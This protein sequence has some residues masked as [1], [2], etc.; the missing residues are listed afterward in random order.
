MRKQ[1]VAMLSMLGLAGSVVRVQSQVLKGSTTEKQAVTNEKNRGV[2]NENI[3]GSK[4]NLNQQT[5]RQQNQGGNANGALTPPPPGQTGA[6]NYPPTGGNN[7]VTKGNA[8]NAVT[9]GNG[10]KLNLNQQTLRQQNQGAV[11]GGNKA[12]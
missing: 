11:N 1:W 12:E 2:T 4:L 3:K 5:L 6:R 9:K 10:N 8:N 7:A